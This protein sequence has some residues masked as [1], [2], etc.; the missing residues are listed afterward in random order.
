MQLRVPFFNKLIACK[1]ALP[2][3]EHVPS[4][5]TRRLPQANP[6]VNPLLGRLNKRSALETAT[7]PF[8]RCG[9]H[10][11]ARQRWQ[12]RIRRRDTQSDQV[13]PQSFTAISAANWLGCHVRPKSDHSD[14]HRRSSAGVGAVTPSAVG[15]AL[16]AAAP[17]LKTSRI[18]A[19][20]FPKH[21]SFITT[22]H[23]QS[24][25]CR[26]NSTRRASILTISAH[27]E[28]VTIHD[29]HEC[30]TNLSRSQCM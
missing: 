30:S 21:T 7:C 22:Q 27:A 28:Q 1:L 20:I 4:A 12:P 29:Q 23:S 16:S 5:R 18:P 11:D 17:S 8:L 15:D 2:Q 25:Q 19:S 3:S 9:L 10:F 26:T 13:G 6:T 24:P 14:A